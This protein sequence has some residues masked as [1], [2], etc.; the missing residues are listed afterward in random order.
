MSLENK[1]LDEGKYAN[2]VSNSIGSDHV[3]S[4]Y[5]NENIKSNF[6]KLINHIDEPFGDY[7]IFPTSQAW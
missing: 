3:D 6:N 4:K 5:G 2:I 1:L 7:S